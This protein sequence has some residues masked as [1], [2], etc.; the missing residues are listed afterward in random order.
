MEEAIPGTSITLSESM[1][2]KNGSI[3]AVTKYFYDRNGNLIKDLNKEISNI[4]YNFKN[5]P[6]KLT[7]SN[8]MS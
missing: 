3:I 7:I 1:D 2:F 4:E 5:L 8:T 6:Q